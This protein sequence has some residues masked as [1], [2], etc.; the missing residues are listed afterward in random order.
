MNFD[1]FLGGNTLLDKE[2]SKLLPEVTLK[3]DNDSLFLVLNARTVA[4]EHF[5]EGT[6]ELFVVQVILQALDD[7][8][9]LAACALLVVQMNHVVLALFLLEVRLVLSSEVNHF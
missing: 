1:L 3:L 9:A 4:M 5:L 6:E 7:S 2:E 8:K